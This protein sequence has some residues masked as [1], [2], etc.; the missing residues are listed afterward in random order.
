MVTRIVFYHKL[1]ISIYVFY[2]LNLRF[3]TKIPRTNSISEFLKSQL[4]FWP[5]I[6]IS[7]FY[8]RFAL[9]GSFMTTNFYPNFQPE[10]FFRFLWFLT[11]KSHP[12]LS[13]V[14]LFPRLTLHFTLMLKILLFCIWFTA[15]GVAKAMMLTISFH[16]S[17]YIPPENIRKPLEYFQRV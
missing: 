9:Q 1:S 17:C 15:N 3:P 6:P 13:L 12:R 7:P 11:L 10:T 8:L 16:C 2:I 14:I 4:R 5:R